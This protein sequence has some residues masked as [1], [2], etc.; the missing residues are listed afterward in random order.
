LVSK[1]IKP[2]ATNNLYPVI[3]ALCFKLMLPAH[4]RMRFS[5]LIDLSNYDYKGSPEGVVAWTIV[6]TNRMRSAEPIQG[7]VAVKLPRR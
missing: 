4:V 6:Y 7:S 1:D 3:P 5:D 2:R